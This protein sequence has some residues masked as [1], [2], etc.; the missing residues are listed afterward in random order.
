MCMTTINRRTKI[1]SGIGYM[2]RRR[3]EVYNWGKSDYEWTATL[4]PLYHDT[5]SARV[6]DTL[7]TN[8]RHP[9]PVESTKSKEVRYIPGFHVFRFKNHALKYSGTQF[10][11]CRVVLKVEFSDVLHAGTQGLAPCVVARTVKY[12][13]IV[14]DCT[15]YDVPDYRGRQ[16]SRQG[17]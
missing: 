6:G 17:V 12:L 1:K 4:L 2:V 13:E 3:E 9:I 14:K 7:S 16:R 11:S 8:V 15:G 5:P 10:P